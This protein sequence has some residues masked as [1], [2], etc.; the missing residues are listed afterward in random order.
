VQ[1]TSGLFR[2]KKE[3]LVLTETHLVRY[4]SQVRASE[5]FASIPPAP[6]RGASRHPSTA[7]I[8]S[9]QEL[10][11]LSSHTSSEGENSVPLK[12]VVT[13]YKV[14]DGRPFF[15]TEVVFL[16]EE[17]NSVGSIQLML[18][19]PKEADLW[20]TSIRAAAQKARLLASQ[21]FPER[22]I[23][24]LVRVV[25]AAL[26]YDE[27]HFQIFRVVRRA[28]GKLSGKTSS[29]DLAKLG[30]SVSYL[31][32]GLNKLHLITLP[33]H[34]EN[35]SRLLD[36]KAN[37]NKSSYGLVTLVTMEVQHADDTFQLGF[38]KPLEPP[39]ML[40]L[41][42]S[43]SQEIALLIFRAIIYLKPQWLDYTFL[44]SG[45]KGLLDDS[46][47]PAP[48]EE[49]YG[50]FDR[51]L[52]AYCAAYKCN[53]ANIRY[54]VDFETE[55]APEFRLM[56]PAN[57]YD[58]TIA[59]LLAIFRALRYNESF[60]SVSFEGINL[61]RLHTLVDRC[62]DD[63][64]AWTSRSGLPIRRYFQIMPA[65]KSLLYQE[66]Q[67][68][69]LKSKKIR[70]LNFSN[71]LPRRRPRDDVEEGGMKDPGCEILSALLP[72][73]RGQLTNVDWII[74][75]GIELGETDLEELGKCKFLFLPDCCRNLPF[76]SY[77]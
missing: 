44:F 36:A 26:D 28:Q 49:E 72:L 3:Y 60:Q 38:R 41:A 56:P 70:R 8:S 62:G 69:A 71:T 19:D 66:V 21:P 29:D 57:S 53:T 63:H 37:A 58:Y 68:L 30:S 32:I 46:D 47:S 35:P 43:A 5:V 22:V 40:D 76:I 67:A 50:C 74:L 31:V 4:K 64:V 45:P 73:C 1:T 14:E 61:Q 48:T 16:D 51:T 34:G 27:S 17:T 11:S 54:A 65:E 23:V 33:D 25:E 55:D 12:Q 42:A 52:M 6:G 39:V 75:S 59:E 2:K 20:H 18:N 9:L 13:A 7:S 77:L 15:T 24:Y 10:Q